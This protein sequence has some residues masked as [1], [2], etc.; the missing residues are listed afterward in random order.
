MP[1][2][3]AAKVEAQSQQGG[4]IG[5]FTAY[6]IAAPARASNKPHRELM[7]SPCHLATQLDVPGTTADEA[8]FPPTVSGASRRS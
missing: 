7:F 3:A 6:L 5:N 1:R 2:I 8:E 4:P